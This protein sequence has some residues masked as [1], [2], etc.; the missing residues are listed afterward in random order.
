MSIY[1]LAYLMLSLLFIGG[2]SLEENANPMGETWYF[3]ILA[4]TGFDGG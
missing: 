1:S 4:L 3:T 2:T